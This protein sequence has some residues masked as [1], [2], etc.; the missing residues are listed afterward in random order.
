M[1]QHSRKGIP[2]TRRVTSALTA[3]FFIVTSILPPSVAAQ[4]LPTILNLPA[5]G[6]MLTPTVGYTPAL[7]KGIAVNPENPL[8]F[9][10][11]VSQGDEQ[12]DATALRQTS[13]KLIKYFL[14][15]LTTP[16]EDLWVNLSPH[17]KDRIISEKFGVT[18][19]GRDLLAQDYILKQMTASLMYPE[20][21][22]GREFWKR[23]HN[24][25]AEKYGS[26]QIPSS[27]YSKIWIVPE[28]AA[29]YEN[30]RGAF[31]VNSRLKVLMAE[32]YLA[33]Q[34]AAG[35]EEF[36]R[37]QL[38]EE[39]LGEQ[40]A[41]ISEMIREILVP[42]I[43]KEVNQGETFANL[44][45]VYNSMILAS[46][47]KN[48]L[49]ETLLGQVYVDREKI[50]GVDVDDPQVKEK[51]YQQYLKAFKLGVYNYIKEEY[52]PAT[53][54]TIPRQYFSGGTNFQ[55]VA[56]MVGGETYTPASIRFADSTVVAGAQELAEDTDMF[57][58]DVNLW[59][60]DGAGENEGIISA[61]VDSRIAEIT[62]ADQV[63][64]R[65]EKLVAD[66]EQ[67]LADAATL[68]EITQEKAFTW[69]GYDGDLELTTRES[70]V[71]DPVAKTITWGR[72][73]K[74][75][76]VVQLSDGFAGVRTRQGTRLEEPVDEFGG[77]QWLREHEFVPG[78]D[79]F[80]MVHEIQ[81]S[82]ADLGKLLEAGIPT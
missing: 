12:L 23:V 38:G 42:E 78:Y 79:S 82:T 55:R 13:D 21:E 73:L 24:K 63:Q 14:A 6:V 33:M 32:D 39:D 66:A 22:L 31:V 67:V 9:T 30:E 26:T 49:R 28:R 47:F 53:D 56:L 43:E 4:T 34:K 11:Y 8:N 80:E 29:V 19:M 1:F 60:A 70:L 52:D 81:L 61:A 3:I 50:A 62:T 76:V 64:A 2:V 58:L 20:D 25:A 57:A 15:T 75:P 71:L 54:K 59:E 36:A 7:I 77:S 16:S 5:P 45:Q 68:S 48:N 72:L 35:R 40:S 41:L 27:T 37:T 74:D 69:G 46:W 17:E 44:R 65:R 18:E 51:I 10:F